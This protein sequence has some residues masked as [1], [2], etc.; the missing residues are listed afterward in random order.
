MPVITCENCGSTTNTA[1]A[2]WVNRKTY[3]NKADQCFLKFVDN[4]WV[5]GCAYDD[6]KAHYKKDFVD[7]ILKEQER[8]ANDK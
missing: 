5:K 8:I 1:V 4:R 2:D 7:T 3:D 6:A